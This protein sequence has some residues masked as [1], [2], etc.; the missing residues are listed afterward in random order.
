MIIHILYNRV[1]F[2]VR[3]QEMI[4]GGTFIFN[5]KH[6]LLRRFVEIYAFQCMF[7]ALMMVTLFPKHVSTILYKYIF[8]ML[9]FILSLLLCNIIM[10][11]LFA[12]VTHVVIPLRIIGQSI[13]GK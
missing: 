1:Q 7:F 6:I 12:R 8:V 9:G 3:D 10:L 5:F 11:F 2:E 4:I 13:Y